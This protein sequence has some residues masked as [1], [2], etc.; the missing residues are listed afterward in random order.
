[1]TPS[2]NQG[3]FLEETIRSVLLQGYPNLEYIVMDGGSTDATMDLLERYDPWIDHW[4]SEPDDGQSDAINKGFDRATGDIY[5]WLNS[6]DY[7]A[8]DALGT[9]A[10]AFSS[11][12]DEVGAIVGK[13]HKVNEEGEIVYTPPDSEL[14]REAFLNWMNGG[15]F[16]Q[17]ACFFRPEAWE[18]AGPLRK[19]LE[20]TM[21]VD[22]WL[23]MIRR[24]Q[25]KRIGDTIAYAYAH[26]GAKTTEDRER[27][28]IQQIVL[29]AEHGGTEIA[30]REAM[31]LADEF[32][33][34]ADERDQMRRKIQ[35]VTSH[36]LYR[37]VRPF[38]N[39]FVR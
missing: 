5:T 28:R 35:R 4:V 18:K 24:Y 36:P 39:W 12:E 16:M 11:C 1:M 25:F 17:P 31:S 30:H 32:A 15:N 9:M 10:R 38:Y 26:Q 8:P 29:V 6:D 2:Y 23:K 37:L 14:T 33:Q 34:T 27:M 20:Y 21:D 7:Y 13:G 19:D 22:L 3:Q